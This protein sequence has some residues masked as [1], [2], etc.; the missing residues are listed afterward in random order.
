MAT[1]Y[2]IRVTACVLVVAAIAPSGVAVESIEDL[3]TLNQQVYELYQAGKL[4]DAIP[5]VQHILAIREKE[6]GPNDPKVAKTLNNL[7]I[8]YQNQGRYAEAEPLL[9]RALS[10]DERALGPD[11]PET[12]ATLNNLAVVYQSQG[13]YSE[14][15]PLL[16]RSPLPRPTI[17]TRLRPSTIWP[18]CTRAKGATA[19]QSR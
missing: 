10:I 13:R 19:R 8:L 4:A 2:F 18:S 3:S 17:P 15:E 6:L 12:V 5:I 11:N 16:K 7:A 14:A 9:R 1:R